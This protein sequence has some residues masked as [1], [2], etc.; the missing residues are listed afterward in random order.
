MVRHP[1]DR[2]EAARAAIEQAGGTL[3]SFYWL[4]GDHHGFLVFSMPSEAAAAAY[5]ATVQ[6]SG[7]LAEHTT[8]QIV[9]MDSAIDALGL[10]RGMRASYR[11]PGAAASWR[12]EYD[13]IGPSAA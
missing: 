7:R 5:L 2:A 1:S 11:P 10:A 9:S 6:A 13:T 8:H 3:E 4:L 12:A